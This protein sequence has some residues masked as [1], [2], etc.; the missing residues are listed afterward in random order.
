M[1]KTDNGIPIGVGGREGIVLGTRCG[2]GLR[3]VYDN[4]EEPEI[5]MATSRRI[6]KDYR[7]SLVPFEHL[8]KIDLSIVDPETGHT[9]KR[10]SLEAED[11]ADGTL[12]I[13]P[14]A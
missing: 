10:F 1:R 12:E 4:P 8:L 9:I 13:G 3:E 11:K 14:S 7:Q 2:P 6:F 5:R